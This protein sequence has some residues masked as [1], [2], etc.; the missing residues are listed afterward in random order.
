V[1]LSSHYYVLSLATRQTVLYE[2][3][4][5]YLIQLENRG[6]PVVNP[7][8][9]LGPPTDSE[10]QDLGRTIDSCFGQHYALDPLKVILVGEEALLAAISA[11][12]VHGDAIVGR[13]EGDHSNTS[14]RDL[15]Q[16]VWPVIREAMTGVVDTALRDLETRAATG[17]IA[18]GLEAVARQVSREVQA[19]VLVE[20]DYHMRGGLR[21]PGD[22]PL[23]TSEVDVRE[24]LDDAV[25]A[26]IERALQG[27]GKAV[28]T[29]SGSLREWHRIASFLPN[30]SVLAGGRH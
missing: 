13:V 8:R 23:I 18:S 6:F 17:S 15:G 5:N 22:S 26:V 2:A 24:A 3:F 4:R 29:P 14:G 1:S 20:E 11:V 28:F 21:G 12:T 27:G 9:G 30:A 25:D 10:L 19:T 16:I 7:P